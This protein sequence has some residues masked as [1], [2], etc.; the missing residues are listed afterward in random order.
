M[1][2]SFASREEM[3]VQRAA[4]AERAHRDRTWT[5]IRAGASCVL[6]CLLG[7]VCLMWSA[8]T[9]DA[10]YGRI[11]FYGGLVI[12]NGGILYTLI[13]VYSRRE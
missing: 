10:G 3:S 1:P 12:G 7:L 9:T 5:L 2:R 6:W 13:E 8:H 11:A 4:E